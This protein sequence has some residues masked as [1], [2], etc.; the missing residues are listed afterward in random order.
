[1]QQLI[2]VW[3]ALEP[4]RR[5]I[6]IL[7]SVAMFA[8][9]IGLSRMATA[10][11][12]ALLYSGL[13]SNVAG[14]V[15]QALEQRGVTYEVR[16]GAIYVE[17]RMRDELR[18]TLASEGLPANS[19]A[20]YELLDNLSGFGTTAQMFDAAYWRAKEGELARTIVSSPE[21]KAARVH[22][23]SPTSQP[24]RRQIKPTASVTVTTRGGT[25][26]PAQAKALKYLVASAVAGLAPEDVSIID[27]QG[28]LI[29][30]GDEALPA[31]P[32]GGELAAEMKARV[33]RLLEAHVGRGSAVVEVSVETMT[34]RESITERRFD[35][36]GRV[37][38]STETEERTGT[39]KNSGSGGAVTVASNLPS[40]NAGGES[41]SSSS[42]TSETRERINYEI[43]ET[44]R[45]IERLPGA[46]KR[47]TVA[48]LVDGIS[49]TNS[50]GEEIVRPR[51]EDELAAL[52]ELVASAVG[53]QEERGDVI[54]IKSMAFSPIAVSGTP[55]SVSLIE[56]LGIDFMSL[57]RLFVLAA[58][59][60]LLGLFVVRPVLKSAQS[61]AA[62]PAP[63]ND[64]AG[65]G[66]S[67]GS[68]TEATSD[69]LPPLTGEISD[70]N[71]LP[72][73][74]AVVSDFDMPGDDAGNS[75]GGLEP[76]GGFGNASDPV[77]RLKQMIEERQEETVEILR[78]WMDEPKERT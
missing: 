33:E 9:V 38:I 55:A 65:L 24:F 6:A 59:V 67:D 64:D 19:T 31:R 43:S 71:M 76:L 11:N 62:L 54:T 15:I 17:K 70:S 25:L 66:L 49:E 5:M 73:N 16:G 57:I 32:A 53:L 75:S 50:D 7:A 34:E 13:G 2:S 8:G 48:V 42:E 10:P 41:S 18:M 46:I 58:V 23:A 69:G 35:P 77:S 52:K 51:T 78:S 74:M 44:R 29:Q 45:E 27:S 47:L 14:E 1:M 4:R 60:L 72:A 56:K 21:I 28:G 39:N 61:A 12:M 22:I 20:G 68:T 63:E 30:G 26:P 37:A 36:E 40:G 3:S